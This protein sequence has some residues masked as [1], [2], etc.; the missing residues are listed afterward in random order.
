MGRVN[1]S[2]GMSDVFII[3]DAEGIRLRPDI[4]VGIQSQQSFSVLFGD[5]AIVLFRV[6][7]PN[8]FV[9]YKSNENFK[10]AP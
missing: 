3:V 9:I 5:G 2:S 4:T 1:W 7:D 8:N 10:V 6:G